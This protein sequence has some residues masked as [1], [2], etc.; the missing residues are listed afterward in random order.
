VESESVPVKD[1]FSG[2]IR[3]AVKVPLI[4][5]LSLQAPPNAEYVPDMEELP[6][7]MVPVKSNTVPPGLMEK[8]TF[9]PLTVPLTVPTPLQPY[10]PLDEIIVGPSMLPV[11]VSSDWVRKPEA[12]SVVDG[13]G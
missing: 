12:D 7:A 3:D 8:V 10:D 9:C 1:P 4:A 11:S 2:G 13:V 6:E 5:F